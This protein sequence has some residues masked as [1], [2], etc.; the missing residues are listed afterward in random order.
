MAMTGFIIGLF[1]GSTLGI[2]VMALVIGG[3]DE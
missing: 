2:L 3:R 1:T